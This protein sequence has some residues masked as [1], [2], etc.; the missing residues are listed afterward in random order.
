LGLWQR[1]TGKG[2]GWYS[3]QQ[4]PANDSQYSFIA[5]NVFNMLHRSLLKKPQKRLCL[6]VS[7]EQ[8]VPDI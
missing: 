5:S 7:L 2:N 8:A 4:T 1:N 6:L 3:D